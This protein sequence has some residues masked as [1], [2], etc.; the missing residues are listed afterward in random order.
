TPPCDTARS[1][2]IVDRSSAETLHI[3]LSKGGSFLRTDAAA[4]ESCRPHVPAATHN[5]RGR[6]PLLFSGPPPAA[7]EAHRAGIHRHHRRRRCTPPLQL[8]SPGSAPHRSRHVSGSGPGPG[9]PVPTTHG[10]GRPLHRSN[11]H[12]PKAAPY[13]A[14]PAPKPTLPPPAALQRHYISV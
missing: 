12:P 13:P 3:R 10:R 11:R 8:R 7:A 4:P 6:H 14:H 1:K 2:R 9:D 5:R